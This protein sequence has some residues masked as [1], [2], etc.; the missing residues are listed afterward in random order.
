MIELVMWY[1]DE[2]QDI[3]REIERLNRF[4]G[5]DACGEFNISKELE[6]ARL[7]L[8]GRMQQMQGIAA[9][10]MMHGNIEVNGISIE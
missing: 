3:G 4:R 1:E 9:F 6:D 5:M 2:R 8:R 7:I 10:L